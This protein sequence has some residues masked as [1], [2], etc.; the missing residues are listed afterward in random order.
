MK[1]ALEISAPGA[2]KGVKKATRAM[3]NFVNKVKS[4]KIVIVDKKEN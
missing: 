3:I 1:I 2:R 4:K